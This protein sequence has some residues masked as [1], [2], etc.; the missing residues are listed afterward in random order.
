MSEKFY[1]WENVKVR[2]HILNKIRS[3]KKK[4]K[5]PI[6]AFVEAAILDKL[7]KENKPINN[8]QA[9]EIPLT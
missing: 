4:T 8:E 3:H 5:L 1:K 6:I 2:K 9:K 7:E